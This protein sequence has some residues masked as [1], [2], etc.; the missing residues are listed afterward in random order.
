MSKYIEGY[1]KMPETLHNGIKS[2]TDKSSRFG[3]SGFYFDTSAVKG[4]FKNKIYAIKKEKE[5]EMPKIL[6]FFIS[7]KKFVSYLVKEELYNQ[8]KSELDE[9]KF[10]LIWHEF[11]R[12][13]N[14]EVLSE[15]KFIKE[16]R[17][18]DYDEEH[19]KLSK[20]YNLLLIS[21]DDGILEK[22]H[23]L[24]DIGFMKKLQDLS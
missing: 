14:F 1:G 4:W 12:T 13:M 6:P 9:E 22:Y 19:Y 21:N 3:V 15:N 8:L 23:S 16:K 10:E 11:L 2:G 20:N 5:F 7:Q 18:V 17:D 24:T